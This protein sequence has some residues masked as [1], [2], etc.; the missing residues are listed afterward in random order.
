MQPTVL[1]NQHRQTALIV[2]ESGKKQLV[3][4]LHKGKL[5]VKAL[6][7]K[8]IEKRGYALSDYPPKQAA[9]SYL[10]HAAGVGD[11]AR[12]YLEGVA[13]GEFSGTLEFG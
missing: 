2:A 13:R 6:S 1:I 8:D 5:T 7:A 12:E 11:R 10:S 3:V 9:L 4:E